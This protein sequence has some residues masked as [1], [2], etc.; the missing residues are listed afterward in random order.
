[1]ALRGAGGTPGGFGQ[2]FLGLAIAALG[3]YLFLERVHVMSNLG[4]LW[5]GHL[6]LL[7]LP[8]GLG[9]GLLF[10]NA[11]SVLG[12]LMVIV[13]LIV[14]VVAIIANLT[15]FFMPTN[16]LRTAAMISLISIGFLMMI[17]SFRA[18]VPSG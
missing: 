11:R 6:G 14:V 9:V 17:R 4:S 1:M 7:L 13:S 2:F 8:L 16:F 18:V 12:W 5:G 15:L 10:F 3:F